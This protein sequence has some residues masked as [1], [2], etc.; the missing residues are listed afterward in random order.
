[1]FPSTCNILCIVT[2]PSYVGSRNKRE[3][4]ENKVHVIFSTGLPIFVTLRRTT[5]IV[6]HVYV[7]VHTKIIV[8]SCP[9]FQL[10]RD[11]HPAGKL[12]THE[13]AWNKVT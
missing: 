3:L 1:M 9:V 6:S 8:M 2:A 11:T 5:F 7:P 10:W 12:M 13:L 4:Y